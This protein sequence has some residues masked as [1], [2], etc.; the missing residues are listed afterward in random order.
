MSR[1]KIIFG[2]LIIAALIAA[3][4]TG[5]K[6]TMVGGE[7]A[8]QSAGQA[9]AQGDYKKYAGE[10]KDEIDYIKNHYQPDNSTL[11][12]Y[13][14]WLNGF[15]DKLDLTRQMYN[16]TSIA[17]KKYLGYLNSSSAEYR[18][19][20]SDDALFLSDIE[21]LNQSYGQYSDYLDLSIKKLAAL[22]D[23]RNK[24]NGTQAAYG[25]LSAFAKDAKVSSTEAYTDF[26]NGFGSRAT[27]FEKSVDKAILAGDAYLGYIEPGS[28]E[29]KAIQDNDRALAD[30][31]KACWDAYN[32]YKKD[33]DTKAGAKAAAQ[34]TF[35]DYGDKVSRA[36]AAKNDADAYYGAAK[37]GEKLDQGWLDGFKQK[38]D[39]F[40]A[41]ANAAIDAGT[42]CKQYLDPAGSD[43]KSI[44]DNEK[45]MRDNIAAYDSNYN[46][47]AKTFR[48]LHPLGSL[49]K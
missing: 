43:Y 9:A 45:S 28:A 17:A 48:T 29:Y 12:H 18:N 44:A 4:C 36:N 6:T 25:A 15:R 10:L 7:K 32:K 2:L 30:S 47:V 20:T 46:K 34:T 16:N 39:V 27:V 11:D 5:T 38:I 19:V 40:D 49:L 8:P 23:Y 37:A 13:R 3:G 41:A 14:V 35:K 26:I 33:Y 42:A 22:D 21:S 31:V 24:L 1:A